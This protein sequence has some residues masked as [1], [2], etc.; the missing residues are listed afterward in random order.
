MHTGMRFP[1]AN[2]SRFLRERFS[3]DITDVRSFAR[4]N[5]QV[6]SV[7]CSPGESLSADVTIVRPIA[8]VRH[9]VLLQSVIFRKRLAALLAN[10][11]LPSFVLQQDVLIEIFLRDHPPFADLAF[12]FR[13][14]VRPLLVHVKGVAV[15]AGLPADV[16][17]DWTLF[18][19]EPHV[20]S[21]VAL[22]L[23][24]LPAILAVVLVLRRVL[25]FQMFL[26][27][28]PV[29][30]LELADVAR[31][32]LGLG[33]VSEAT[34]SPADVSGRMLSADVRV[35]SGLVG[36][37][38][39]AE[40]ASVSQTLDL[41][42]I[43]LI[44]LVLQCD[45]HLEGYQTPAD[46]EAHLALVTLRLLVD[47]VTVTLQHLHHWEANV[48]VFASVDFVLLVEEVLGGG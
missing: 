16:A 3:A 2:Q 24:L 36:A 19:L 6:L 32:F 13:L 38:V 26:Q 27:P 23:E 1:V 28:A 31:V 48:A 35:E 17:D 39:V 25:A 12:V 29:L 8:R 21:H 37:L 33:R 44:G 30:T 40:G 34:F 5:E 45:V 9:H 43:L 20:E 42:Q 10:E 7:C 14:E 18:V 41:L 11:T 15:R 4:V 47:G 46:L 22:Y